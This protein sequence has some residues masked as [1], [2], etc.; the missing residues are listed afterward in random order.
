[1]AAAI[2]SVSTKKGVRPGQGAARVGPGSGGKDLRMVGRHWQFA[3]K[4][5]HACACGRSYRWGFIG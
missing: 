2:S 1:V 5:A 4:G 3:E